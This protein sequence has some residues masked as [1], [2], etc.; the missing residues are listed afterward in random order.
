[1]N[2]KKLQIKNIVNHKVFFLVLSLVFISVSN[3]GFAIERRQDQFKT[4][5][6]YLLLP[7][8]YRVSGIGQGIAYLG[9]AGN[10]AGTYLNV[11]VVIATGDAEAEM[12]W[13]SDLHLIS[14]TLIFEYWHVSA[15]KIAISNY[16][17]RGLDN[18]KND[19]TILKFSQYEE[20]FWNLKLSLF[21]RRME[22]F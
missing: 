3:D 16:S 7:A 10:I 18:G 19:Y 21:E 17:E 14:E 12:I 13:I 2:I 15:S 6:S 22:L 9:Q 11:S 4:D 20:D 1:M 8:P 5:S